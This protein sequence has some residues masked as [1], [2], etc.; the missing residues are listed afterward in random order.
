VYFA[1][2]PPNPRYGPVS[3]PTILVRQAAHVVHDGHRPGLLTSWLRW[4]RDRLLATAAN[5]RISCA[6]QQHNE[7]L[8]RPSSFSFRLFCVSIVSEN[9]R[10]GMLFFH[11]SLI[12]GFFELGNRN[13]LSLEKH[14]YNLSIRKSA[15][16]IL[17]LP[18]LCHFL[19][20]LRTRARCQ[21]CMCT[22]SHQ[23]KPSQVSA[24]S[25]RPSAPGHRAVEDADPSPQLLSQPQVQHHRR[26]GG[27]HRHQQPGCRG[28]SA[29]LAVRGV[30]G[31]QPPVPAAARRVRLFHH[32]PA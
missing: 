28:D 8:H 7:R 30:L 20:L 19:P 13:T 26:R 11:P 27:R 18:Y 9:S 22:R 1:Q 31:L 32:A 3:P 4:K 17:T 14:H 21:S 10:L 5:R 25:V 29:G 24:S 6:L 23:Y 16:V 15:T 2:V 12:Y